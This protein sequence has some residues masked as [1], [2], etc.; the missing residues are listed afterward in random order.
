MNKLLTKYFANYLFHLLN[1]KKLWVYKDY[2][3]KSQWLPFDYLKEMQWDRCRK[4]LKYVYE[5]V[6]YYR[7]KF[8]KCAIR[9][10]DIRKIEDYVY[11]PMLT[12]EDIKTNFKDLICSTSKITGYSR[13]TSGSSGSPLHIVKDGEALAVM[14]AVMFRNYNWFDVKIGD[15]Q[16]RFWG[17]PLDHVGRAKSN[18][19]D[20]LLNRIRF[21]P[22]NLSNTSYHE[23]YRRIQLFKPKFIYGYAQ[24][25]Y[26]FSEFLTSQGYDPA[27]LELQAVVL[28]GEM[29]FDAQIE[30]I[31]KS[32]QC[33][34]SNEYGCTEAGVIAMTCPA[35]RMH[36]MTDYL[37]LEFVKDG[38]HVADEEEGEII[39]TEL[40]GKIMPLVRY[41]IED[42]GSPG[43]DRCSCGRNLPLLKNLKGRSD[44]FII[45]PD[46]KKIDPIFFEYILMAL[47]KNIGSVT[48]FRIVQEK[49]FHLEIDICYRGDKS[50][51]ILNAIKLKMADITGNT[52]DANI[53][54]ID[55]IPVE[56]SGKLR[57]FISNIKTQR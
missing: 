47:P 46:G 39:L 45:C 28:T 52:I 32:F 43:K 49:D 20:M 38:N 44:D 24:T 42:I 3:E 4:M 10:E 9:P 5:N 1:G 30:A 36:L 41:K 23:C 37:F 21:S 12:K 53:R 33:H 31:E 8:K 56:Q 35:K 26:N 48:Q 14:D 50:E 7:E 34:V 27:I 18:I 17:S 57:C 40:Y 55:I 22:F 54:I 13:K 15:K 2:F 6:P 51:L 19:K 25:V 16:A 29:I 11:V